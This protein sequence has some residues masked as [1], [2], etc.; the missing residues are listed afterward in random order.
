MVNLCEKLQHRLRADLPRSSSRWFA[1][2]PLCLLGCYCTNAPS[3]RLR[4]LHN[5]IKQNV[6]GFDASLAQAAGMLIL[7]LRARKLNSLSSSGGT[8]S[9]SVPS[10]TTV[11]PGSSS[12]GNQGS[13]KKTN[14]GA[15]AGG[16]VGGI[17][18]LGIIVCVVVWL[19]LRQRD[20]SS[21]LRTQD[22]TLVSYASS[23]KTQHQPYVSRNVWLTLKTY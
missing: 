15:I 7:F 14:S 19:L 2:T 21:T 9:V 18:V 5:L 10:A 1:R 11:T 20:N 8:E 16:V 4:R 13:G 17:A 23:V 12:I 6:N 22:M 3:R